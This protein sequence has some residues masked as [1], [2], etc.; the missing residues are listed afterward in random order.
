MKKVTFEKK[1]INEWNDGEAGKK[2]E[3]KLKKKRSEG[4][5]KSGN[6][7]K[8]KDVNKWKKSQKSG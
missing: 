1:A 5:K 2:K 4:W 6:N 7:D 3:E 8:E